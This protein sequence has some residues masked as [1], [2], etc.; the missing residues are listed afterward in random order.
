[1]DGWITIGTQLDTK[2]LEKQLKQQEKE[3]K[4]Y[5]KEAEKLTTTKAKL[6]VDLSKYYE[7][8]KLIQEFTDKALEYAQTEKEV[9]R[10]LEIENENLKEL[11]AQYSKE[12]NAVTEINKKLQ[13][14][15]VNQQLMNTKIQ[16]T[17]NELRRQEGY[18]SLKDI[19]KDIGKESSNILKKVT[20]WGLAIF[21]VRSV[22]SLIRSSM[23]TLSQYDE[24]MGKNIEYIRYALATAIK[25]LIEWIINAVYKILTYIN[26]IANAWFGVNLFENA[27]V[28]KFNEG[29]NKANKN[30]KELKKTLAGFDEV[31]VLSDTSTSSSTGGAS[32]SFD[33][34]I[35]QVDVP[36]WVKWIAEHKDLIIEL[37]GIVGIAFGTAKTLELL[38]NIGKIFGVAG[39]IGKIGGSGLA[40]LFSSLGAIALI[41]GSIAVIVTIAKKVWDDLEKLGNEIDEISAKQQKFNQ[42]AT[43]NIDPASKVT[44]LTHK[45]QVNIQGGR[46]LLKN[47]NSWWTKIRG[48]SEKYETSARRVAENTSVVANKTKEM[49]EYEGRTREEKEELLRTLKMQYE[50]NIDIIAQLEA[51]GKNTEDIKKASQE[52]KI[53]IDGYSRE[54]QT[55][56]DIWWTIDGD[57]VQTTDDVKE[58]NKIKI[59]DKSFKININDTETKKKLSS[60][61]DSAIMFNSSLLKNFAPSVYTSMLTQIQN[62]RKRFGLWTGGIVNMPNR[63][64]PIGGS[65]IAGER[66]REGVIP[67]TDPTAMSQLGQEIGQWVNLAIDNKMV[68]DGR[69]LATATN[70]QI[71]KESFLMNR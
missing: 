30:A 41:A 10:Q 11:D 18:T 25:P 29:M 9:Q 39:G 22:Y 51:E 65:A 43:K 70:N 52:L 15:A 24:K 40:G 66:G 17:N 71:N 53:Q 3:L 12:L 38:N 48:N 49:W 28:D 27:G 60:L 8:K 61:I 4:E 67:L 34:S 64:V 19:I 57:V 31:N 45:T 1:M 32:P 59:S 46:D 36:D 58:L 62:F 14:N 35:Q 44:D 20:K 47:S 6:E 55:A 21:S 37:A 63:G 5:E 42:E 16:Q 26:Y 13:E 2:Q 23:S 33:L 54:L 56:S 69:V 7:Q 50:Y 68:V